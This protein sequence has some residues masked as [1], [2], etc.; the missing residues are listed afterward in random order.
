MET[1][2]D[3][4]RFAVEGMLPLTLSVGHPMHSMQSVEAVL[5]NRAGVFVV[6]RFAHYHNLLSQFDIAKNKKEEVKRKDK[7]KEEEE[8]HKEDKW[9]LGY[10]FP[11][12]PVELLNMMNDKDK[13][14]KGKSTKREREKAWEEKAVVISETNASFDGIGA[15]RMLKTVFTEAPIT[16][17]RFLNLILAIINTTLHHI[18]SGYTIIGHSSDEI[19][20]EEGCLISIRCS[21][22]T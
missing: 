7:E 9:W 17:D 13:E 12:T 18:Q 3:D 22:C 20:H 2:T 15:L 4:L 8:K 10:A 1:A 21:L 16:D 5:Y 14:G 19:L 6:L 11:F